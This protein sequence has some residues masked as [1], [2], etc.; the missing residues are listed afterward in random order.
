MNDLTIVTDYDIE[1]PVRMT[2][3]ELSIR[4]VFIKDYVKFYQ[5]SV[6]TRQEFINLYENFVVNFNF[7]EDLK[8]NNA[9]VFRRDIWLI[10]TEYIWG[11]GVKA[12]KVTK[13]MKNYYDNLY[14][15]WVINSHLDAAVLLTL[16]TAVTAVVIYNASKSEVGGSIVNFFK[17]IFEF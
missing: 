4:K 12:E 13:E 7:H 11:L 10:Q 17:T 15:L 9:H 16:T 14:E 2:E 3:Y 8:K 6:F 1:Y 5:D